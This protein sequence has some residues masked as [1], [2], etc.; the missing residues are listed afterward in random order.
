VNSPRCW[1]Q[2]PDPDT[3]RDS[4]FRQVVAYALSGTSRGQA[5]IVLPPDQVS[6]ALA[7][8]L[9]LWLAMLHEAVQI[10]GWDMTPCAT[11]HDRVIV[12]LSLGAEGVNS[13]QLPLRKHQVAPVG[14]DS[15]ACLLA[16]LAPKTAVA[17][18]Q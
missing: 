6:N 5:V 8:G 13:V 12:T 16:A 14:V 7:D 15:V 10:T 2:L 3:L 18:V 11:R 9:C 1:P 17:L 4:R